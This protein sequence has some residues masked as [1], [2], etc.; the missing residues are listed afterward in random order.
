M[1]DYNNKIFPDFPVIE[2]EIIPVFKTHYNS[3]QP[4]NGQRPAASAPVKSNFNKNNQTNFFE[5]RIN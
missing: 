2:N 5:N 4:S 1:N 3:V